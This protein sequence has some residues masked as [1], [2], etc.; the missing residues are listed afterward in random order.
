MLETLD[1]DLRFSVLD[2]VAVRPFGFFDGRM[3][4]GGEGLRFFTG[5][6]DVP[7]T[8]PVLR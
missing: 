2:G 3:T 1:K 7:G 5:G 8:V 6:S 4:T